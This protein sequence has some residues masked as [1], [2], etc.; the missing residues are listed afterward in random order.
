MV[1]LHKG[2]D[3]YAL[4]NTQVLCRWIATFGSP[5]RSANEEARPRAVN[6]KTRWGTL[7]NPER[8]TLKSWPLVWRICGA[9][10]QGPHRTARST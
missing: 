1:P 7:V 10:Y 8:W 9:D 6:W 5:L 3:P 4:D 2:G